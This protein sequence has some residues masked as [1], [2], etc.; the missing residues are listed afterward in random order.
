[1]KEILII[2]IMNRILSLV[3]IKMIKTTNL[4]QL[5]KQKMV[6][7]IKKKRQIGHLLKRLRLKFNNSNYN[8]RSL[9]Q[10]KKKSKLDNQIRH[11]IPK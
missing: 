10:L 5:S 4:V 6:I 9:G 8:N 7:K 1:M 11:L 3:K 2:M